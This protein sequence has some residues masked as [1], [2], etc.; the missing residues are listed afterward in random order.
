MTSAGNTGD[1]NGQFALYGGLLVPMGPVHE[2]LLLTAFLNVLL[3]VVNLLP[4]APLDGFALFR[5]AV[6]AEVGNRAEA[7]RRAIV[8]S[9][10]VLFFGLSMSLLVLTSSHRSTGVAALC[11]LAT[12]TAQHRA[13]ARRVVPTPADDGR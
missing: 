6:W 12:L 5:S 8:W 10:V 1:A 7:E 3:L 4:V 11:V 2:A 13:A 9:R